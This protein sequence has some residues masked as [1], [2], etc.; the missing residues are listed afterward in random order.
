MNSISVLFFVMFLFAGVVYVYLGSYILYLNAKETINRIF[1]I[2]ALA[3][4]I[5]A[6][7]YAMEVIATDYSNAVFWRRTCSVGWS[8]FYAIMLH[9]VMALLQNSSIS[10]I[11]KY[12]F[13][14][15]FLLLYV[16]SFINVYI[17][18]ISSELSSKLFNLTK[19]EFGWR[20]VTTNHFWD[21]FFDAYYVS[22]SILSIILLFFVMKR[23]KLIREKKQ[24]T[25]IFSSILVCFV[26]GSTTDIIFSYFVE[27]NL[28]QIAILFFLIPMISMW[29]AIRKYGLMT[30]SLSTVS[31][32]ILS[33]MS[34]GLLLLDSS[35][36][37]LMINDFFIK[38]TGYTIDKI[39]GEKPKDIFSHQTNMA[40]KNSIWDNL[41]IDD[42]DGVEENIIIR[43]GDIIPVM[44]SGTRIVDQWEDFVG[45]VCIV[46]NLSE[47]RARE[48]ELMLTQKELEIALQKANE[49]LEA[50]TQFLANISHEIRTPMNS[51]VGMSYLTLQ[52]DL[53]Q[54]Q[55]NYLNKIHDST[56]SLLSIMSDMLDFSKIESG[57]MELEYTEFDIDA[58]IIK[59]IDN[60]R[61]AIDDKQLELH[62]HYPHNIPKWVIGDFVRL[63]QI[64]TNLLDNAIKFTKSGKIEIDVAKQEIDKERICFQFSIRDT[65]IGISKKDQDRIFD[66]FTQIDGSLTR[67]FSGTG[68]GLTIT[69][70]LVEMMDGQIR[71]ESEIGVGSSFTFTAYFQIKNVIEKVIESNKDIFEHDINELIIPKKK[72]PI[73]ID[74]EKEVGIL[75]SYLSKGD[76]FSLDKFEEL[77]EAIRIKIS[78]SDYKYIKFRLRN[79]EFDE[80]ADRLKEVFY[81]KGK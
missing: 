41:L 17:Y 63:G 74:I 75:L 76:G 72:E 12:K 24:V 26:A 47:I 73:Q 3:L 64:L 48:I 68:L 9:F 49:A 54:Q 79:Y 32:D 69:K 13:N 34:E 57:T 70:R 25:L 77:S 23:T 14:W 35:G 67:Q 29:H 45:A 66:I 15:K 31:E 61:S 51:I 18:G 37:I 22:Y 81:G 16:P 1:V 5:W 62:Y 60:F 58:T 40:D 55:K 8:F 28:P 52:T 39:I 65:G 7:S 38:L 50:K 19:T 43:G 36:K 78:A 80:A 59:I 71:L 6:F 56:T 4:S 10:K 42:V 2:G 30:L 53:N 27:I 20:S 46:T 21:Y 11:Q 33:R 44:L